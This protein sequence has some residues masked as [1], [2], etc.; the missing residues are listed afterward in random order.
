MSYRDAAYAGR[1]R[2]TARAA[3]RILSL[4][5]ERHPEVSS[6]VDLGCG[7]GTWL[8]ALAGRGVGRVLG[9]DGPW[10][11][12]RRLVIPSECFRRADLERLDAAAVAERFDLAI[13]LEVAEHL[14]AGRAEGFVALLT[15]LADVVLFS[16]AVPGQGGAGH[17]NEQWPG[18]W[19]RLFAVRGFEACDCLRPVVW[20]DAAIPFWYRQN[21]LL[22]ARRAAPS[23]EPGGV[24][25]EPLALVHP[26]L[27]E[28]RRRTLLRRI[29]DKTVALGLRALGGGAP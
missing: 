5:L 26:E 4:V 15:S 22:Y 11:D 6:A 7:V 12:T 24:H 21:A 9:F 13:S 2:E 10:V 19:A 16:A 27:W 28:L 25:G 1:H 14:S 3:E 17:L 23:P 20:E 29:R 18:Y 8:H